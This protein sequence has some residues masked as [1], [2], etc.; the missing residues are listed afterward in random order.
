MSQPYGGEPVA[1]FQKFDSRPRAPR[2]VAPAGATDC[3]IH[4]Y[5][6]L[7]RYPL[8]RQGGYAPFQD[9]DI[10]AALA[11]H[12]AL[13]IARGVVVQSTLHGTDHRILLD[14]LA[15]AGPNYRGVALVDD[16]VDDAQLERL[17]AA[18]VRGAR[19]NFWSRL[20]MAPTPE[21]FLRAADR[22][23]PLGWHIKIH[24]AGDE[25]LQLKELLLQARITVVV[26]HMG[27]PPSPGELDAPSL[28][29]LRD[30]QRGEGWWVMISNGDR[31]SAMERG[32][33][34]SVP[35]M[36]SFVEAAPERTIW[37]TDWP[38][39][40]YNK[41]MPNDAELLELLYD[42]CPDAET[43]RAVLVRN[44]AELFGF[45]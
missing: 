10:Q 22:I 11:M 1:T 32:W 29:L 3:Q 44:P 34:D 36:R 7:Q 26:D 39:V 16:T 35:L 15:A 12:K 28:R 42:T 25:W 24:A 17:H 33:E 30:M 19:F 2:A 31:C 40:Q 21:E 13:G 5:G 23:R 38:H 37:S 45:A 18:G 27:H 43:L 4:V 14:A 20:K 8:A 9:A 6:D 41:P